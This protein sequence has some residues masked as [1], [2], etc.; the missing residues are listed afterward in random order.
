MSHSNRNKTLR[1]KDFNYIVSLLLSVSEQTEWNLRHQQNMCDFRDIIRCLLRNVAI[2]STE[3]SLSLCHIMDLLRSNLTAFYGWGSI[4]SVSKRNYWGRCTN[5]DHVNRIRNLA[6]T[7]QCKTINSFGMFTV[8]S[9]E[10]M[11]Q[12]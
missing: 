10:M 11:S 8:E 6:I 12:H 7:I 4:F 1:Y 3:T 9:N 5:T 2:H